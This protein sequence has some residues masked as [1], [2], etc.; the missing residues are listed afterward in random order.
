MTLADRCE[1]EVR[2]LHEF[3]AGWLAG[4]SPD[5]DETF[6]RIRTVL[7]EEFEITGPSGE[8]SDRAAILDGLR[9]SHG[10]EGEGFEIRIENVRP[11]FAFEDHCLLTYEEHQRA[12]DEETARLST[13][14]FGATDD[15]PHGVEWLHLQETWLPGGAPGGQ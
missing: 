7:G 13:V 15:A 6:D 9:A 5:D 1:R 12:G 14:L 2:D 11:R 4:D 10:Q 3:F 8:T